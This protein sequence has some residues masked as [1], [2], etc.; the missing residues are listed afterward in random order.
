MTTSSDVQ[1]LKLKKLLADAIQHHS[2]AP[3]PPVANTSLDDLFQVMFSCGLR[4]YVNNAV[5]R[6]KLWSFAIADSRGIPIF[7]DEKI[8]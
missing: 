6:D 3:P 2:G 5:E 4:L 1:L 8:I 7:L